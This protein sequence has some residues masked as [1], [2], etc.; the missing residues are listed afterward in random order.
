MV[1]RKSREDNATESFFRPNVDFKKTTEKAVK[2]VDPEL[3]REEFLRS[4]TEKLV[5][6]YEPGNLRTTEK[7]SS[8][9]TSSELVSIESEGN[10]KKKRKTANGKKG[11]K[12]TVQKK[13]KKT[14]TKDE[15]Y[16]APK[17]LLKKNGYELIITEKPQAALKIANALGVSTKREI[18]KGV[19]YY[20][21]DRN[22]EKLIVACAVGHLFTLKQ[23]VSGSSVPVFD[24]S[25]VP[26]YLVKKGDFTKKYYDTL[27]K[28][29]KNAGSITVATDFDVEG[30]VI[31]KNVIKLICNQDDASRMKFSTL[32]HDELNNSYE[33]K[34]SHINWEQAIAGESRHYL[35]WFYGINLSRALMNAIKTTG[36][37]KVMSIGRV[38]GPA[39]KLVVE[40]EREIENFKKE[41]YWQVSIVT[42]NPKLELKC[43]KD[44]FD[45][46]DLKSFENLEGKEIE[47]LTKKSEEKVPPNVPFDLTSLQ[48]ETYKLYGIT[49][50]NTLKAT[51]SLYLAGLISYP[52][53]SSQKLPESIGYKGILEILK[54]KF[55][56]EKLITKDKPIEGKKTDPAHP[57]IYPTGNTQLLSGDEEKIYNLIVKRFLALFCDDAII[58]RK[59]IFGKIGEYTF[60]TSGYQIRKKSWMEFYPV[61]INEKELPDVEGKKKIKEVKI[62]EKETQPPRRYSPA[63]IISE[64]EKRNLGTKAT[65]AAIIETLYDR[66]YIKE[67]S[68][69]ATPIGMSLIKT[70]E[71]YSPIIIDEELT[72]KLQD[73][74]DEI[75]EHPGKN[76]N[77]LKEKGDHIIDEA[78]EQIVEISKEF[79]KKEK[80][81]GKELVSAQE[82]QRQIERE[83]NTLNLCPKCKKNNLRVTYSPKNRKFF[84]ACSGYPECKNTYSLPPYGTIKQTGKNCEKCNFPLLMALQK[85]KKPWIFCFNTECPTNRER[86]EEYRRKMEEKNIN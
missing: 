26:N 82:D 81:I 59:R 51:Q 18:L 40:K 1:K 71:K 52:R 33:N 53:T 49:P 67:K 80:L 45:K 25:W 21:V 55:K 50:S 65:R 42:L 2:E 32:T 48:T 22:G 60:S 3:M 14:T 31:G 47:L 73:E 12:K 34:S 4:T 43:T 57:S 78:K 54:K 61:K 72:R 19:P 5:K 63:S 29:A 85:G 77:I 8:K 84:I 86:V 27:L 46:N 74:M 70:L 7:I 35:D 83:E 36:K 56:V 15:I 41:P 23:N 58:D 79:S 13:A 20:E 37:F 62:E 16:V 17:I 64:L 24:I 30:E 69:E 11:K 66:G 44:F 10:V 38:Q 75:V 9:P 28:L 39:L 76:L 68:I 6:D